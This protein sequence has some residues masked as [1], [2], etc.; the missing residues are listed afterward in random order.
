MERLVQEMITSGLLVLIPAFAFSVGKPSIPVVQSAQED[1]QIGWWVTQYYRDALDLLLPVRTEPLRPF[2]R[3]TMWLLDVRI[4][5]AFETEF[6]ISVTRFYSGVMEA[7]FASPEGETIRE[8]MTRIREKKPDASLE[9]L[10]RDVRIKRSMVT[11]RECPELS[12]LV[13]KLETT[14][15][16]SIPKQALFV[17]PTKYEFVIQT[18]SN[19]LILSLSGPG[20]MG[21][22]DVHPLISWAEE[23]HSVLKGF[24]SGVR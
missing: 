1:E 8:Q 12:S 2:P 13:E 7:R 5:P 10:I 19:H 22:R 4:L 24:C 9:E 18:M 11:T 6:Q 14:L 16:A 15:S 20:T 17:D 23:A 3:E 21:A